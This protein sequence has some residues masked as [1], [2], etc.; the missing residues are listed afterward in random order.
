MSRSSIFII[1]IILFTSCK[2]Q[3]TL[4][5][6]YGNFEATPTTV[7]A[8]A[9]GRLLFLKVEEG[10]QLKA[11][12]LIALVD[13]TQ[14]DLQRKQIQATIN[15]LPQKLRTDLA[16]IEVMKNQ[17]A[18]L[19]RE[20]DRVK[21]LV[22]KKAATPKQLDDI[23]GEIDVVEKRISAIQSQTQ[24]TNRSILSEKGPMLAQIDVVNEQIRKSYIYNPIDGTVLTKLTEPFEMV[25]MGSPLYRIAELDTMT[26][27][28]YTSAVQLQQVKLGEH[29]EVLVD[30][31]TTGYNTL[32]GIV[33]WISEQAEFTPKTI[34]TKE[35]RVNLVYAVK[36]KVANPN[37]LLKIGMPAEV[38]FKKAIIENA[39]TNK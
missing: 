21:R 11:A 26:L 34:Q 25:G 12:T 2:E 28:F 3:V 36:A 14:L 15:T 31:G 35:D 39:Q 10:Q 30:N 24:T 8:E 32:T 37:G 4:S 17:K 9:N 6:A 7:S 19:T 5:D 16:D 1:A 38:N 13:T 29:I 33:S 20:R 22:E 27:R 23:N 18:N